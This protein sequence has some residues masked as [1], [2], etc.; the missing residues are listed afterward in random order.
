M[1][2]VPTV[3][4]VESA[5]TPTPTWTWSDSWWVE[6]RA[7][8]WLIGVTLPITTFVLTLIVGLGGWFTMEWNW[9]GTL[10]SALAAAFWLDVVSIPF[11][12]AAVVVA[13]PFT[14]LLGRALR[15]VESRRN[16]I[17]A[18]SVLAGTLAALPMVSPDTLLIFVPMSIA[19]GAAGALARRGEFR[20]AD[21]LAQT[22]ATAPAEPIAPA[23]V[24]AQPE[25]AGA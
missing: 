25:E 18:T 5:P 24:T 12:F 9:L 4:S 22:A 14:Y 23:E 1:E 6:I 16:Q 20:R 10:G 2:H 11:A 8:G 7:Y 3:A 13:L 21:R 15:P 19:A 17:T